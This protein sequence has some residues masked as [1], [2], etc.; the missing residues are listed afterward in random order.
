MIKLSE[1]KDDIAEE[2][3][4]DEGGFDYQQEAQAAIDIIQPHWDELQDMSDFYKGQFN[5]MIGSYTEQ[6]AKIDRA[7]EA[8]ESAADI[9]RME[10]RDIKQALKELRDEEKD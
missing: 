2:I 9:G 5:R 10:Y 6:Q 4:G 7:I 8:L 1:L 3:G